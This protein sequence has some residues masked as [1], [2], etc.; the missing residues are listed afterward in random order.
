M[1]RSKAFLEWNVDNKNRHVT[2]F[3]EVLQQIGDDRDTL[4]LERESEYM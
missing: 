1:N 4:W 3:G 2:T